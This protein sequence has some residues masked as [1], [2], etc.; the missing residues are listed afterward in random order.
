MTE[1]TTIMTPIIQYGF[2][3][4]SAVLLA[5]LVWLIRELL[6]VLKE[7]NIVIATNTQAIQAV[8]GHSQETLA[9]TVEMKNELLK[10]PCIA[11]FSV[12]PN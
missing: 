12:K 6:K 8:D 9:V 4:L 10:R 2:A 7:N 5:I 11:R 3:G 1:S